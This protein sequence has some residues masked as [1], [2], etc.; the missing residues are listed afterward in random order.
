L[1]GKRPE[2]QQRGEAKYLPIKKRQEKDPFRHRGGKG[3]QVT[4]VL[5]R[6]HA[7]GTGDDR[8]IYRSGNGMK[9]GCIPRG[10][11]F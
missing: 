5:E 2:I 1:S 11:A 6:L 9:A 3:D 7:R 4:R 10:E 8:K